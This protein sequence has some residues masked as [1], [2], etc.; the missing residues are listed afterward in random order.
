MSDARFPFRFYGREPADWTPAQPDF[1]YE[2]QFERA[3]TDAER[4]EVVRR[5]ARA[6]AEGPASLGE[7]GWWWSGERFA[8]LGV[9]ERYADAPRMIFDRVAQMLVDVHGVARLR[10]VVFS[11]A[12]GARGAGWDTWSAQR[13]ASPDPGPAAPDDAP[14]AQGLRRTVDPALGTYRAMSAAAEVP[15]PVRAQSARGGPIAFEVVDPYDHP[16]PQPDDLSAFL[17]RAEGR[18]A[19]WDE[20]VPHTHPPLARAHKG[21]KVFGLAWLDAEGARVEVRFPHETPPTGPAAVDVDGVRAVV[22]SGNGIFDLHLGEPK[23]LWR[24]GIHLNNG[25]VRGVAWCCDNLWAVLADSQLMV[26]DLRG[27]EPMYVGAVRVWGGT[28][29]RSAR[30]GTVLIV[31]TG[32]STTLVG[33]CDWQIK[34]LATLPGGAAF[35]HEVGGELIFRQGD[36]WLRAGG[37]EA[38]YEAWA[39]P[40]RKRA[41]ANRKRRFAN[42]KAKRPP[43]KPHWIHVEQVPPWALAERR[44]ALLAKREKR[45]DWVSLAENGAALVVRS[46]PEM[47]WS[48][49]A[50]LTA[51]R[52]DGEVRAVGTALDF[53]RAAGVTNLSMTPDGETL[54]VVDGFAFNVHRVDLAAKQDQDLGAS[55]FVRANGLLVD[56]IALGADDLLALWVD[57]LIWLRRKGS[58][59]V[60]VCSLPVKWARG[61]AWDPTT[62]RVVITSQDRYRL[63]VVRAADDALTVEA[64]FTDGVKEAFV[65]GS[66]IYAEMTDGVSF[67]LRGLS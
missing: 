62:R 59:L 64:R 48:R 32:V 8:V 63:L 10:D 38:H 14:F 40:L 36:V 31:T 30:H 43:T 22:A 42:G 50:V 34:T 4:D 12:W 16:A 13:R 60:E 20:V 57:A 21:K 1:T 53:A 28:S 18:A 7:G 56:V 37:V 3:L 27:D 54:W 65:R 35:S 29:L 33:V 19:L 46:A 26:D 61:F 15:R 67:A 23:P 9:G 51:L 41:E 25:T 44:D 6:L 39:A 49:S 66:D 58:S 11:Q 5:V 17:P 52:A 55:P 47:H 24:M 2:L 45:E